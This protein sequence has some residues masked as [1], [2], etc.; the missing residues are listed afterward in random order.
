[1]YLSGVLV[2]LRHVGGESLGRCGLSVCRSG[3]GYFWCLFEHLMDL[4][5][6]CMAGDIPQC[7]CGWQRTISSEHLRF[8]GEE[9][10][11]GLQRTRVFSLGQSEVCLIS[12]RSGLKSFCNARFT[13]PRTGD[14]LGRWLFRQT[15]GKRSKNS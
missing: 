10:K 13:L 11:G 14:K 15:T 12:L 1:M 3:V 8:Y 2:F 9:R 7:T 4:L 6:L 5:L